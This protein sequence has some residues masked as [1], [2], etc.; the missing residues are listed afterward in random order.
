MKIKIN[1]LGD[2][3][4]SF[5]LEGTV[6]DLEIE[7]RDAFPE[8]LGL[9]VDLDRL[10]NIFRCKIRVTTRAHYRC[11]RCLAEFNTLVDENIEQI[12]QQGS[13]QLD[14]E[15]DVIILSERATEIDL[16]GVL[17]EL[18]V[19]NRPIQRLC[20]D[21]CKGL[22]SQCGKNLNEGSCRCESTDIDPRL[23]GLKKLLK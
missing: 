13:G 1:D 11:D 19:V 18:F 12:Y 4:H 16:A 9:R 5:D 2:G 14:G 17:N 6:T 20:S 3:L 21:D 15:D 10:E 7:D 22:C 8:K 23:E